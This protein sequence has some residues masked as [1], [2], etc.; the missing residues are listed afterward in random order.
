VG[1]A[2]VLG[3]RAR[4]WWSDFSLSGAPYGYNL[5]LSEEDTERFLTGYLEA[6]GG[7]VERST[8]LLSLTQDRRGHRAGERGVLAI[9]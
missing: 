4:S 5:G 3:R 6:A 9:R 1:G 2:A 8:R 7:S